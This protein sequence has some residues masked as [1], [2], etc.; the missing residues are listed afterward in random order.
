MAQTQQ[1]YARPADDS[2]GPSNEI[3]TVEADCAECGETIFALAEYRPYEWRHYV[4][5]YR[6]CGR[7]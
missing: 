6:E 2:V 5:G 7:R 3:A 4:T 1:Q